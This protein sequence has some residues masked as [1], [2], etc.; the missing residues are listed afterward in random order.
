MN[1]LEPILVD[2]SVNPDY[3][4]RLIREHGATEEDAQSALVAAQEAAH[5]VFAD[6][7]SEL[8][9]MLDWS[10]FHCLTGIRSNVQEV[11]NG[12]NIER[13]PRNAALW[14]DFAAACQNFAATLCSYRYLEPIL[15]EQLQSIY[16]EREREE[17]AAMER[18]AEY[19]AAA[20]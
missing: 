12:R 15:V 6:H 5:D 18:S 2:L 20:R 13:T 11:Y 9:W 7:L 10:V 8:S 19:S 3:D 17:R 1:Y 16:E 14:R 4:T